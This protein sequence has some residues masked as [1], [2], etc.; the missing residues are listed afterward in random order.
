MNKINISRENMLEKIKNHE[1]KM[2][3]SLCEEEFYGE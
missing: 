2:K 1:E 3:N